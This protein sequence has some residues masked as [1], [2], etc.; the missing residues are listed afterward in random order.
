MQ[1]K[2]AQNTFFVVGVPITQEQLDALYS[3]YGKFKNK[4]KTS[5]VEYRVLQSIYNERTPNG[6]IK[7]AI[8]SKDVTEFVL[9]KSKNNT[10]WVIGYPI[11]P[12][13]EED[14]GEGIKINYLDSMNY[15]YLERLQSLMNETV[16]ELFANT[17]FEEQDFVSPEIY[18]W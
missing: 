14:D 5:T 15:G 1:E 18:R 4:T 11:D 8:M 9:V 13:N 10:D 6:F 7:D 17:K 2:L 16:C 3:K 12:L